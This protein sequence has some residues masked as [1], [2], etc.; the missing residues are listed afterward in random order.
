MLSLKSSADNPATTLSTACLLIIAAFWATP[1]IAQD[2]AWSVTGSGAEV[3]VTDCTDCGDDIGMMISCKGAG[4]PA[5]VLVHW[6]AMQKG[7]MGS[8]QPVAFQ[9][10]GETFRFN[11]RT[12][13]LRAIGYLPG[14]MLNPGDPLL[15]AL[16]A[17]Q[18]A[19]VRFGSATTTIDLRGAQSAIET[20][21][22][23]CGWSQAAMPAHGAAQPAAS[24][25]PQAGG[26]VTVHIRNMR[27]VPVDYYQID[28]AGQP[29]FLYTLK[30]GEEVDQPSL[31]DVRL[32]FGV[33][34]QSIA[35][36]TTSAEVKQNFDVPGADA[37]PRQ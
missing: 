34:G 2:R 19:S 10:A 29:Q 3:V 26:H 8:A 17:G 14:F 7:T 32:V 12:V 37:Q 9:V 16:Q 18:Q 28:Q 20:F 35:S 22:T 11:A 5:E 24:A 13:H 31:P 27:P 21:K 23:S 6:A 33:S 1:T 4:R 15:A 30:P 25:Q 36:Y